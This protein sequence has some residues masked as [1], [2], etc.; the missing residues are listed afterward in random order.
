MHVAPIPGIVNGQRV[1]YLDP[2]RQLIAVPDDLAELARGWAL[3]CSL[4]DGRIPAREIAGAVERAGLTGR[5]DWYRDTAALGASDLERYR[6]GA[7]QR[8]AGAQIDGAA[9]TAPVSPQDEITTTDAASRYGL[10][11]ETWRRLAKDGKIR[12]RKMPRNVWMLSL[13]GVIAE[14]RRRRGR[15]TGGS[16]GPGTAGAACDPGGAAGGRGGSGERAA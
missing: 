10:S 9:H 16:E 12:A 6:R 8:A 11:D 15:G 5:L 4:R 13:E 2:L 3:L 7:A 1:P 14:T